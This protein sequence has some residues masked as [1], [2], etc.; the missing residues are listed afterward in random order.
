ME[1]FLIMNKY[2]FFLNNLNIVLLHW[3]QKTYLWSKG[4]RKMGMF[5]TYVIL[6]LITC[7]I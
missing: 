2:L 1:H 4:L 7:L 3:H 6:Y 5:D